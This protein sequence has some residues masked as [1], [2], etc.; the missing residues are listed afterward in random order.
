MMKLNRVLNFMI[1][2]FA[3][4]S[5]SPAMAQTEIVPSGFLDDYGILKPDAQIKGDYNYLK[6]TLNIREYPDVIIEPVE[7]WYDS[8]SPYKGISPDKLKEMTE[9]FRN[10][11]IQSLVGT[12]D[13][14]FEPGP[15]VMSLRVAITN[16]YAVKPKKGLLNYTPVGLVSGGIKKASGKDYKLDNALLE[17]ELRDS[18]TGELLGAVMVSRLGKVEGKDKVTWGEITDD[19]KAYSQRFKEK[20]KGTMEK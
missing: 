5:L 17:G 9:E 14:V 6:D 8:E 10:T 19:F 15:G 20:L 18:L 7:V 4:F 13:W 2:V 1:V 12:V 11:L 16:V 3:V